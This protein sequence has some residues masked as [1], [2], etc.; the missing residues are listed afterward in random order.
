MRYKENYNY[1]HIQIYKQTAP[2]SIVQRIEKGTN[3][4]GLLFLT[5]VADSR[6]VSYITLAFN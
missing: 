1:S 5:L 6:P 2:L 3:P 4:F